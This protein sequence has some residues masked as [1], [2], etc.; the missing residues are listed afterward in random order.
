MLVER[1]EVWHHSTGERVSL[2]VMAVFKF[3][4]GKIALW[5]DY[6]D[7]KTLFE[8]QPESWMRK[9]AESSESGESAGRGGHG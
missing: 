6:W 3:R 5:R 8:Q 1:T 2:P 7:M 9:I 4:D